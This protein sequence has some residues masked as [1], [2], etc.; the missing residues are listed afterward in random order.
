MAQSLSALLYNDR[1]ILKDASVWTGGG[2]VQE[3]EK[4][5]AR[6]GLVAAAKDILKAE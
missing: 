2:P 5:S 3:D 6:S 4:Q 1:A